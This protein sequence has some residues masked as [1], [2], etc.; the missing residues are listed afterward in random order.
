MIAVNQKDTHFCK[1]REPFRNRSQ[2]PRL[3]ARCRIYSNHSVSN[4]SAHRVGRCKPSFFVEV[5]THYIARLG[6]CCST[7]TDLNSFI[8]SLPS[9]W[10]G[11]SQLYTYRRIVFISSPRS[12]EHEERRIRAGHFWVQAFAH[13]K[14][15]RPRGHDGLNVILVVV[16]LWSMIQ[17][18]GSSVDER[19]QGPSL[20]E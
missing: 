19:F 4:E 5:T 12:N 3:V 18:V 16:G 9:H 1:L 15:E 10:R 6:T 20:D 11:T 7:S 2:K 14:V 17:A 13:I 8:H